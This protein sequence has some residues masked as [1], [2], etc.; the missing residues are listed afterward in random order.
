LSIVLPPT[1]SIPGQ[2]TIDDVRDKANDL[3]PH[4]DLK[5]ELPG[6]PP[7]ITRYTDGTG[8]QFSL[9]GVIEGDYQ[10]EV[11]RLP[12]GTYVKSVRFGAADALNGGLHIDSRTSGGRI[13][14]V[15]GADG[16]ALDGIA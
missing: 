12:E 6:I 3:P 2:T 1:V 9:D 13:E 4:I 14:I 15:L 16:G 11:T 10:V 5:S 8:K 7:T